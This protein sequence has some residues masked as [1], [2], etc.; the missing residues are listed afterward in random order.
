MFEL[1]PDY[2]SSPV[3]VDTPSTKFGGQYTPQWYPEA[4]PQSGNPFDLSSWNG[5]ASGQLAQNSAT[6]GVAGYS[7]IDPYESTYES[8]TWY[9]MPSSSPVL[10][11]YEH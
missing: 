10:D 5:N 9:G 8:M 1:Y 2:P 11:E 6:P 7:G 4:S 3:G